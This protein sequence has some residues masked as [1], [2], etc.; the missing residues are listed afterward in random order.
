MGRSKGFYDSIMRLWPLFKAGFWM[1]KQPGIGRVLSPLFSTKIHQVTMIP[2]NEAITQG[3]QIVLPY[4]LLEWLVESA[5]ARFIMMECVCRRHENCQSHPI[6]MGCLFLGDGAAQIH[7]S[8][9]RKCDTE[10]AKRHIQRG[11]EN[12]LYPLIAHTIIEAISMGISYKRMLTVCFCCECCCLVHRGLRKGP[13]SLFQVVQRM[14]GLRITVE[15]DCTSCGACIERCPVE[16][17]SLNHRGAE[18][19]NACKGCGICIVAC[20]A[21]AIR[22]EIEDENDML[23]GFAKQMQSYADISGPTDKAGSP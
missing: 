15:E 13:K 6:D 8:L 7:P 23:A 20:P 12:G 2:V 14:P 1:G 18:I 21:N 11:L 9:G 10:E 17:I 4:S 16:A 3:D 22:M 19:S 5:S